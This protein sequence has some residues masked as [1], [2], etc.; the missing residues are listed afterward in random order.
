M[1]S[2]S[3]H[4]GPSPTERLFRMLSPER[5]EIWLVWAYAALAG[6]M[7]LAVPVGVQAIIGLVGG[8]MLLQPV[9]ILIGAVVVGTALAGGLQLLQLAAVERMQQRIFARLSLG[10]GERLPRT[11]LEE[12]KGENLPE[13]VNRF[14]EIVI[15]QKSLAKLLTEAT[16][17]ALTVLFGLLLLTLY[18]PALSVSGVILLSLLGISLRLAARGALTT[19]LEESGAK[20]RVA[21][22]LQEVARRVTSFRLAGPSDLPLERTDAEV[23]SY[24]R[25]RQAHFE[26][27][28]R[29]SVVAVV[30]RTVI[31]GAFL[32]LG[33][34]LVFDRSITLGQ[35]VAA[36]LVV[37]G[38]LTA[39]E[40]LVLSLSTIYDVL[41]AVTKAAHVSEL[42]AD[43]TRR[44]VVPECANKGMAVRARELCYV[45]PGAERPALE[46]ITFDVRAGEHVAIVGTEGAGQSTLLSVIAGVLPSYAGALSYDGVPARDVDDEGFRARLGF[47]MDGPRLFDGTIAENVRMGRAH[48]SDADVHW[49]LEFGGLAEW[50]S[51]LPD[52][53]RTP[54]GVGLPIPANA[55]RKLS[56]ARAIAARPALL[57]LDEFFHHLDPTFKREL[58]PRLLDRSAGWTII[59]ASHDP[60]YLASCDRILVLV[61]GRFVREGTFEELLHDSA[62]AEMMRMQNE[63]LLPST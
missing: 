21:H 10:W 47:V 62:F 60:V 20:Y 28:I 26:I 56:L 49:A 19:S 36:E 52:G 54:I 30:F 1:P 4:G 25:A 7:S 57:L 2:H 41:T 3:A 18:H 9:V 40:K 22:W 27:L 17:A 31:T 58:L 29:Q 53:T 33:A 23:A 42:P 12:T 48:V 14:F 37:V 35:F 5:G 51:T 50:V 55:A 11:S 34:L 46:D 45:Y 6:L 39:I 13:A 8:G 38:I 43:E 24:L 59:A 16:A 63:R 44:G 32:V 15:I 61:E